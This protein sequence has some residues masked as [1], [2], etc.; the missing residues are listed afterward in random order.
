MRI[1][2]AAKMTGLS[3]SNIR[4]YEKKGLLA[5]V[6]A[7]ESKYRDYSMEDIEQLKRIILY[8]KMNV[9]V[10]TIY[11]LKSGEASL[12]KVL[13][14]QEEEL[15]LQREALQGSIDL[16]RKILEEENLQEINVDYY[17]NYVHTEEESGKR[18]A[19]AEEILEDWAD[20]SGISEGMYPLMGHLHTGR[21]VQNT[22]V[23]RGISAACFLVC[24]VLPASM[25]WS[26]FH[27][28]V[29]P[30]M[31]VIVFWATW[32]VGLMYAFFRF[33]KLSRG[34]VREKAVKNGK[35]GVNKEKEGLET[36]D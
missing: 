36:E 25:I 35:N 11:L 18:F 16:C 22:W 3:V 28:E 23:P 13:R 5:P 31:E 2:E 27:R 26:Q 20:F 19:Q 9:P 17:L 21:I 15:V 8:R 1:S 33:R 10:E 6:R 34:K 24:I 30:R 29:Q 32:A 12:E 14:R 7:E 4:F